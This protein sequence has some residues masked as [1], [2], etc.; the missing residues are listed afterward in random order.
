MTNS[1]IKGNSAEYGA[2]IYTGDAKM[3]L[4]KNC[5]VSLNIDEN[6]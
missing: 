6:Y 5:T 3:S 2:G 1:F 4:F